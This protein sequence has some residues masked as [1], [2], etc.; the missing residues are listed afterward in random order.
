MEL[1]VQ[2]PDNLASRMSDTV[3][4][5]RVGEVERIGI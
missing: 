4:I 1:T 2:I 5:C 3:A